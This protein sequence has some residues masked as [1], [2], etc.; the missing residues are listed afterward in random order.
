MEKY[1]YMLDELNDLGKHKAIFLEPEVLLFGT[2]VD[3]IHNTRAGLQWVKDKNYGDK[4]SK[5]WVFLPRINIP[6][7]KNLY[8][9][10]I[11]KLEYL[12]LPDVVIWLTD[13]EILYFQRLYFKKYISPILDEKI[14]CTDLVDY[15]ESF[16][17]SP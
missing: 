5:I 9:D 12:L 3:H 14:Y 1:N 6:K 10:N 11:I 8:D 15:I 2:L 17:I 13:D 7:F 4:Y 16:L